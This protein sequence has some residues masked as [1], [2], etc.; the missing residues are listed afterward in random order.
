MKVPATVEVREV[1]LRDGLQSRSEVVPTSLKAAMLRGL[2]AA[3]FRKINAVAL[4]HPKSMPQMA[5]AEQL[6]E[7]VGSLNGVVVSG[8]ALNSRGLDRAM[9]LRASGLLQ[10]VHFLHATTNSV[11]AANSFKSDVEQN[12]R[13]VISMAERAQAAGLRTLCFI[14]ASFGCSIEGRVVPDIPMRIASGLIDS[15]FVDEICFSDSTGQA[16]PVQVYDFYS[17]VKSRL[18]VAIT[19]HFHDSRGCALANVLAVLEVGLERLTVDAAFGGL[20]GDVP[21]LPQAAGNLCTEDLISMLDGCSVRTGINL[22]DVIKVAALARDAYTK[23]LPSH[24]L[25]VGPVA[26]LTAADLR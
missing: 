1:G 19:A 24:V 6:L 2:V 9:A 20:G 21:F 4:V 13:D 16:N 15:G 3:G 5:D 12:Q 22:S 17:K 26:W 18:P 23:P 14:S 7:T 25:E 11:L 8:L 10:E